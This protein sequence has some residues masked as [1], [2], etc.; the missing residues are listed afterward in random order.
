MGYGALLAIEGLITAGMMGAAAILMDRALAPVA[1]LIGNWKQ[2]VS[3]RAAYACL[4]KLLRMLSAREGGMPLPKPVGTLVLDSACTAAP[5]TTAMTL[6]NIIL[7][8]T[9]GGVW[10]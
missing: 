2:L 8:I 9:A 3:A 5:G 6:K 1:M 7:K 4:S 10:R